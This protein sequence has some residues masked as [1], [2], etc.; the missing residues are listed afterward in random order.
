MHSIAQLLDPSAWG[1]ML[2]S[3]WGDVD[4]TTFW[5][6]VVQLIW[7]NILLSG[8]NAVVIALACRD[9][10]RRQRIWG[11][12][13]GAGIAVLLRVFFTGVAASLLLLPY[14]KI[15]GGLFLLY[16]AAKLV[17]AEDRSAGRAADNLWHAARIIAVADVVMSFD[18]VVAIA[19]AAEGN[20]ALL[21]LG[22]VISIPLIVAGAALIAA[23]L[24]RFPILVWAGAAL[25]GWIAGQVIATDPMAAGALATRFGATAAQ[26][27]VLGA[28]LAG[29]A[30]VL[31]A[32]FLWRRLQPPASRNP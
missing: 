8:D 23:L 4:E 22:L 11:L 20:T 10:P 7:I 26:R 18:N 13:L 24:E 5:V 2:T 28:E 25:L 1:A 31:I 29:V 9:L 16:I 27:A 19:T 3:G 6:A 14:V 32:G 30:V 12:L 21:V 17:G 15:A